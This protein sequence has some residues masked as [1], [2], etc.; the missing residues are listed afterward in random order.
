MSAGSHLDSGENVGLSHFVIA[1]VNDALG[2]GPTELGRTD[3]S[4]EDSLTTASS[5]AIHVSRIAFAHGNTTATY[6]KG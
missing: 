4:P 3:S 2:L 6:Q 5:I 1:C